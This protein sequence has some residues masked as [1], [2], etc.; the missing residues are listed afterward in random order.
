MDKEQI[1]YYKGRADECVR[2]IEIINHQ[3]YNSVLLSV[4]KRILNKLKE[5]IGKREQ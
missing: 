1:A 2:I 3:L 4:E 5:R